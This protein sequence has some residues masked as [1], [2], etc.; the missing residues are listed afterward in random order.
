MRA[1][2]GAKSRGAYFCAASTGLAAWLRAASWAL[3]TVL[4]FSW[5][6][7]AEGAWVAGFR[8]WAALVDVAAAVVDMGVRACGRGSQAGVR[9]REA[10]RESQWKEGRWREGRDAECLRAMDAVF[11]VGGQVEGWCTKHGWCEGED[12][13]LLGERRL[14]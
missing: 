4:I 8:A 10:A 9:R 2:V 11:V 14:L 5:A 1:G 6:R 13:E 12:A 3:A 7:L